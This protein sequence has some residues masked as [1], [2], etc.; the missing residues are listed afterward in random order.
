ME[1]FFFL[2]PLKYYRRGDSMS[3]GLEWIQ[4][5]NIQRSGNI[6]SILNIFWVKQFYVLNLM[7]RNLFRNEGTDM[8][9]VSFYVWLNF[10]N[11]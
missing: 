8:K 6:I 9:F 10:M 2:L 1:F 4:L 3:E 7:Y 11:K 5:S